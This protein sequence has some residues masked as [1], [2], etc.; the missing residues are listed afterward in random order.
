VVVGIRKEKE[1]RVFLYWVVKIPA[2]RHDYGATLLFPFPS[3]RRGRL[4]GSL[5]AGLDEAGRGALFGPVVPRLNSISKRRIVGLDDFQETA[6]REEN[7]AASGFIQYAVA[8]ARCRS[9]S[10]QRN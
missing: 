8:W 3:E 4:D 6:S 9:I 10:L 1:W 5:L 7:R 2:R